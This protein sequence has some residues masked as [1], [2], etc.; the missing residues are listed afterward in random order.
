MTNI[1][2]KILELARRE[3]GESCELAK[4]TEWSYSF[5]RG[6]KSYCSI[7]R[8]M[9]DKDI[10][11]GTSE[12]RQRWPTMDEH[13]RMDFASNWWH[14]ETWTDDDIQILETI[15]GDGSARIWS[16][17]TQALLRHPDRNR[18]MR[19]LVDRVVSWKEE[20]APLNYFQVLGMAKEERA[21]APIFPWYKKYQEEVLKEADIGIPENLS[22]GPIPY[23][24]YLS[25]T[26]ALFAITGASEYEQAIRHYFDH[27]REQVRW[28]AEHAL[29]IEGP[30]TAKRN[31]EY[32][33]KS[34]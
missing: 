22:F 1:D 32:K 2:T 11:V 28:W 3:Y 21:V 23:F 7:S 30:T 17:C 29:G 25:T 20:H 26:G 27:P 33:Q 10:T 5:K 4:R 13:E 24:P 16:C 18:A 9:V 31:A 34:P 6:S 12:M 8:F 19:F 14:K 15:M